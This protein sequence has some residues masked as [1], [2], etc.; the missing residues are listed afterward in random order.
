MRQD[1]PTTLDCLD[2]DTYAPGGVLAQGVASDAFLGRR[3]ARQ[4]RK[5]HAIG[6]RSWGDWYPD[7]ASTGRALPQACDVVGVH[8]VAEE[9]E[10]TPGTQWLDW[11][12]RGAI[13]AGV[14]GTS[15]WAT[16]WAEHSSQPFRPPPCPQAVQLTGAG[17]VGLLA[18]NYG[19]ISCRIRPGRWLVGLTLWAEAYD[20]TC[21]AFGTVAPGGLTQRTITDLA[22]VGFAGLPYPTARGICLTSGVGAA[23]PPL[24]DLYQVLWA[25]GAGAVAVCHPATIETDMVGRYPAAGPLGW[26]LW[27]L[28]ALNIQSWCV[29]ERQITGQ[30]P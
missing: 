22:G 29:R 27:R 9:I 24:T 11:Y 5:H 14:G 15:L 25:E 30:L 6:R 16:A 17:S 8:V 1:V 19:P 21:L 26:Q 10:V 28:N 2:Q 7:P 20:A 12:L 18:G 13:V 23:A 4:D 3:S